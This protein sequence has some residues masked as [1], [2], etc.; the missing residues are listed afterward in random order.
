MDGLSGAASVI[1]VVSL[2]IQLADS[3]KK[4]LNF[5]DSVQN[6]P[7]NVKAITKG[8][9]VLSVVLDNIEAH[10]K[11]H[12]EDQATTELL[13]SCRDH[14]T[15]LMNLIQDF[16]PGFTS[17]SRRTRQWVALKAVFKKEQIQ[18]FQHLIQETKITLIMAQQNLTM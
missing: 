2:A 7:E 12:G 13:D 9:K 3:V 6:A 16:E 18:K 1:G 10:Q 14:V 11:L 17:Q 8:L 4:L 15:A 5:W